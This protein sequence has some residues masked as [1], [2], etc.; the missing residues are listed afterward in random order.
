MVLMVR[1]KS[2]SLL[3]RVPSESERDRLHRAGTP[4]VVLTN[5]DSRWIEVNRGAAD[6][7]EVLDSRQSQEHERPSVAE[8]DAHCPG[9]Q[10]R[11]AVHWHQPQLPY[12]LFEFY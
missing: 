9:N 11:L 4:A 7:S 10:H 8:A 1:L 12:C 3:C 2:K 6:G 5:Q